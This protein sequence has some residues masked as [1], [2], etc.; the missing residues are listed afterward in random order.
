MDKNRIAGSL[1]Q[2]K[3]TIEEAVGKVLGDA[4][5]TA[6]GKVDKAAGKVQNSIGSLSDALS[7]EPK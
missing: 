7:K 6:V 3:G 2:V 1:K 5:L 4:K